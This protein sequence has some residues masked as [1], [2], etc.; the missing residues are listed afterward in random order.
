ME[1]DVL[2]LLKNY[3]W[4]GN[5]RELENLIRML[6]VTTSMSKIT[7][8]DLPSKFKSPS[9]SEE[10][11]KIFYSKD[12]KSSLDQSIF[13]FEKKYIEYHLKK[14][15]Y[16]ISKTAESINLSRVS[17]HKKIKEHAIMFE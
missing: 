5:I 7:I 17:L 6:T 3:E 13:E 2:N 8:E 14:N 16:N 11:E 12:F 1:S 9:L 15:N 4:P 10:K